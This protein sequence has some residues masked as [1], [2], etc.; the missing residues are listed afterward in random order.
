MN[1]EDVK[2]VAVM[3][4]GEMGHGIAEVLLLGGYTVNIRD[5]EQRF[6]DRGLAKIKESFDKMEQKQRISSQ[7]VTE[8]MQNIKAYVDIHQAVNDVDFVIEAVP[9]IQDLKK[10]VFEEIDKAAP[11]HTII[12]SNTSGINISDLAA[13][14]Q[15]PGKV[16]GMHFLNPVMMMKLVEVIKARKTAT[17]AV[18]ITYDLATKIGKVPI[19][20]EKDSPGFVYTRLNAPKTILL[21]AIVEKGLATPEEIDARMKEAGVPMGPYELMDF[22]G[23]DILYHG[24]LYFS[25]VLS[26]DYLPPKWLKEKVEQGNFGR[27]TG[28]GIYDWS[29]GRPA[30]N[31]ALARKDFDPDIF[32]ALQV[33]EATKLVEEGVVKNPDDIDKAI[34]NGG[35]GD[36]GPLQRG[37]EVGYIKLANL[38]QTLADKFSVETFRPTET[39]KTGKIAG[40]K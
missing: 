5:I 7:K 26:P 29:K 22:I 10:K 12:A 27:K 15:R 3:G 4:S 39:L 13:V 11:K 24:N 33:N 1:I 35:G 20:V 38:C 31:P 6:L 16:L 28:M 18:Q 32:L 25:N 37:K 14:T 40:S 2:K 21:G 23:L 19:I 36:V 17:E 8:M 30:I 9:E 34:I